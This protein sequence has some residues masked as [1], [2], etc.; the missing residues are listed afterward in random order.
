MQ[1]FPGKVFNGTVDKIG[2]TLDPATRTVKVRGVVANP[3]K[4]LKAEMYVTVDVVAGG[5]QTA[6]AGVE[7]PASAVFMM[8]NQYYLF[9]ETAPGHFQAP[10]VK[11]GTEA[12]GKFR[13]LRA[14]PPDKRS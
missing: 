1:G 8:D 3:D 6:N 2:D 13:C 7:I 9:I 5:G 4:L 10:E 12:D 11:V 14:S